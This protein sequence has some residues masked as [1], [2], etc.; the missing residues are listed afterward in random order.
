[1]QVFTAYSSMPKRLDITLPSPSDLG[2]DEPDFTG[3]WRNKSH[4][5]DKSGSYLVWIYL[6]H[7]TRLAK[8][9]KCIL[10]P[11]WYVYAGSANGP[12]GLR[13]RLSRHLAKDKSRRWHI[14]QLTTKATHRYGWA[15]MNAC[16]CALITHLQALPNFHHPVSGFGSSDCQQ[17]QSHLLKW[18][19]LTTE[20]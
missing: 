13:A 11:G 4:C 19:E 17:C 16:E 10:S 14:D 9:T 18:S 5:P 6:K 7:N 12:G 20:T 15:W 2:F 1:M 8:P 3:Y